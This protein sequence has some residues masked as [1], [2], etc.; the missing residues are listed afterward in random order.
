[1]KKRDATNTS[2]SALR[3]AES[4]VDSDFYAQLSKKTLLL[5]Y[6]LAD[7]E[8]DRPVS[9]SLIKSRMSINFEALL[10]ILEDLLTK[11]CIEVQ[12]LEDDSPDNVTVDDLQLSLTP[13]GR[14]IAKSTIYSMQGFEI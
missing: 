7:G 5:I 9:I 14:T 12:L 2:Y 13:E 4:K 6:Q 8:S 11:N 3:A 10:K 1:M